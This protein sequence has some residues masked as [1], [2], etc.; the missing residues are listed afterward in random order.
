MKKI[1]IVLVILSALF[2]TGLQAEEKK[3]MTPHE[4]SGVKTGILT[5]T[6]LKGSEP[7]GNYQIVL[8]V[9]SGHKIILTLPK[10]TDPNGKYLF[11]NIFQSPEFTYAVSANYEGTVYRS[12]F[13]SLAPGENSKTLDLV[14]K[15][16][17]TGPKLPS[18]NITAV[19]AGTGDDGANADHSHIALKGFGQYKYLAIILS[20]AAAALAF[21]T[22]RQNRK[23]K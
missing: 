16:G 5:G 11:K 8:E 10:E 22:F 19:P 17:E 20:I 3:V 14:I 1:L 6:L 13:V 2:A 9:L 12:N 4:D 15:E 18:D 23:R 7:L 21:F